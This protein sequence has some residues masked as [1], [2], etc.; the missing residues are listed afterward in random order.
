VFKLQG[1]DSSKA[2]CNLFHFMVVP[3]MK[4]YLPIYVLCFLVQIVRLWS[5]HS[6]SMALKVSPLQASRL[7]LLCMPC[8]ERIIGLP[9]YA[10]LMFPSPLLKYKCWSKG[11]IAFI[12]NCPAF[13]EGCVFWINV[14][15]RIYKAEGITGC[16]PLLGY[17]TVRPLYCLATFRILVSSTSDFQQWS[18]RRYVSPKCRFI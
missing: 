4:E 6:S 16:S 8:K 14:A 13:V 1:K 3:F 17:S 15:S 11:N 2:A 12:G 18:R 10:P 7:V 9:F 5:F